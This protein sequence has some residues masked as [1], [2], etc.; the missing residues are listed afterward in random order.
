MF[1]SADAL[2]TLTLGDGFKN[3]Q[4]DDNLYNGNSGWA[5]GSATGKKIS[6]ADKDYA[7]FSNSEKNTY[8]KLKEQFVATTNLVLYE[9]WS[10]VETPVCGQTLHVN[11]FD[12]NVPS[13]RISLQWKRGNTEISGAT[14][15]TYTLVAADVGY[16]ISCVVKE[17][18]AAYVGEVVASLPNKVVK[19]DGPEA[20][21]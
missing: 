14:D 1:Y 7:V 19:A 17:K 5:K 9:S 20:P 3:I 6:G 12:C 21:T 10:Y 16:K 2:Q 11:V 4:A 15:Y 8:Y 13:D 18:T